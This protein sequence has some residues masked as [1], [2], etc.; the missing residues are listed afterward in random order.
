MPRCQQIFAGK[1]IFFVRSDVLAFISAIWDCPAVSPLFLQVGVVPVTRKAQALTDIVFGLIAQQRAR[2][3]DVRQ[4]M[5]PYVRKV[6][7]PFKSCLDG[8]SR[9]ELTYAI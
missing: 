9:E 1:T 6:V 3:G 5:A 8:A 2:T 4:G 7:S